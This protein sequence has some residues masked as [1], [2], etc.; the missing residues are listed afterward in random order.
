M[1]YGGGNVLEGNAS[2]VVEL[3]EKERGRATECGCVSNLNQPLC[4]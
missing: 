1:K 3:E 2:R 4:M